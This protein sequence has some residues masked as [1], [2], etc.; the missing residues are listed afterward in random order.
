MTR[1]TVMEAIDQAL[2]EEM[3]RDPYAWT[4]EERLTAPLELLSDRG[5]GLP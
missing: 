4:L 1:I 3:A 2:T 5:A